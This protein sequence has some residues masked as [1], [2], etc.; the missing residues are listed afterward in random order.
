MKINFKDFLNEFNRQDKSFIESISDYFTLSI[1]Y[2][3]VADFPLDEEPI[4]E[5]DEQIT[6]AL[7]YVKDQVL[8]DMSRGKLG[9][10]FLDEYK[11]TKKKLMENEERLLKDKG[12]KASRALHQKYVTWTWVNY[13][14]DFILAKVDPDDE[15]KT[16]KRINKPWKTDID[17]YIVTLILK[18]IDM[19]VFG[20]NMEHLIK[21]LKQYMPKFYDKWN[22]TFKYELESDM[23]KQRI[24]E[25]SSKTYLKGL[26]ECFEQLKDFYDEFEKQD[27]WK[28]DMTR[29]ALHVNIG[30]RD[31]ELKWNPIKGLLLMG[32]MNRSKKTPFVFTDIMWRLTNRFTQSLLDGIRRNL[33]GEIKQDYKVRNQAAR[34]NLAFRHKD[35]LAKHREYIQQNIEKLDLHN[36]KEA[37]DF[38]NQFLIQANSDFYIKEFGIKLVELKN[39]PGYVEFRYVGGVIER[40][41]MMDKILYFCYIIYL[42]TNDDYKKSQYQ[43]KLYKYIEDIK[44]ILNKKEKG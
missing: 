42:M 21:S 30:V 29:T 15:D 17:D 44:E 16:D 32:D 35:R 22:D 8:L 9:Y 12:P 4:L 41:V 20:Q 37:E 7:G 26:N 11:L 13:F 2:E 24:L 33:T 3:L 36:I 23:D 6:T 18:N 40:K 5:D 38:L 43:K 19:F 10:K 34:W 25:F 39:A 28:M 1:E 31:K 14:I 27:F